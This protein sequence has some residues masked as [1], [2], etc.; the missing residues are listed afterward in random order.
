MK[1]G[2]GQPLGEEEAEAE[3]GVAELRPMI[4]HGERIMEVVMSKMGLSDGLGVG[5]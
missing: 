5:N 2:R 4:V 1:S 3:E